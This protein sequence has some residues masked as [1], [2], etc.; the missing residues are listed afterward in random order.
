MTAKIPSETGDRLNAGTE[1]GAVV[2]RQMTDEERAKYGHGKLK[3]RMP[4]LIQAFVD[5]KAD[6]L[7]GCKVLATKF[8][9]HVTA[10]TYHYRKWKEA[11]KPAV[12]PVEE[13][14]GPVESADPGGV[15]EAGLFVPTYSLWV[16]PAGGSPS[17]IDRGIAKD[18]LPDARLLASDTAHPGDLIFVLE[19]GPDG[20]GKRLR[21]MDFRASP[22]PI[23]AEVPARDPIRPVPAI[24]AVAPDIQPV[25]NGPADP[26][27][28]EG[29]GVPITP[30]TGTDSDHVPEALPE[31][32]STVTG[33]FSGLCVRC[34]KR[35]VCVLADMLA[36]A[37][38]GFEL[39]HP[40]RAALVRVVYGR[41][42][43]IECSA[44]YEDTSAG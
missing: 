4:E 37:G 18:N 39:H 24:G 19:H 13:T 16:C 43:M 20:T 3:A 8:N 7:H 40:T 22:N 28:G 26:I 27:A 23:P 11:A 38:E 30:E 34:I 42:P 15:V 9:V 5:G 14:T 6:D 21:E 33:T 41:T 36:K 1:Q 17:V 32:A 31:A 35:D 2:T 44:F 29:A 12:T 25:G 10:I